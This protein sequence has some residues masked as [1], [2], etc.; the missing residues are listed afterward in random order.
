MLYCLF[1]SVVCNVIIYV[2]ICDMCALYIVCVLT[3]RYRHT[4]QIWAVAVEVCRLE[5][6]LLIIPF[7]PYLQ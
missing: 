1:L 3:S 2:V 6:D 7:Q 5:L 4:V